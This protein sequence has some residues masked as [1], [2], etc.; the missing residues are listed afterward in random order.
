M[1]KEALARFAIIESRAHALVEASTF[2]FLNGLGRFLPNPKIAEVTRRLDGLEEEFVSA[3]AEFGQK[4]AN[5][6]KGLRT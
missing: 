2:P 1:P 5:P 6:T 4:Y 3:R